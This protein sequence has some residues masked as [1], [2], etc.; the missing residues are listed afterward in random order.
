MSIRAMEGGVTDEIPVQNILLSVSDKNGLDD[1]ARALVEA[2][3]GVRFFSTG[4]TYNALKDILGDTADDRLVAVSDYTGFPEMQGGLVKTLHPMIHA[5]ILGERNNPTQQAYIKALAKK[6]KFPEGGPETVFDADVGTHYG[7][8]EIVEGIKA[9]YFDM[10]VVNLYPFSKKA[11]DPE[12]TFED[13]RGNIDIGG[14]TMIRAAGK[15]LPSCAVVVNPESYASI[16][17]QVRETGCTTFDQRVVLAAQAFEH[18]AQY[19][20]GIADYF[21]QQVQT[22]EKVRECFQFVGE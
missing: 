14:P 19:D 13:C 4:G 11:A 12:S 3:D 20:R 2:N 1:L 9:V 18:T 21:A 22:P 5:G 10:V 8:V 7:N 6:L 15:N 17:D 16:A